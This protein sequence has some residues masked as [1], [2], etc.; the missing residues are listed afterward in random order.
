MLVYFIEQP[1]KYKKQ[2]L[3]QDTAEKKVN[4]LTATNCKPLKH[5]IYNLTMKFNNLKSMI[6]APNS[7]KHNI[8]SA[9]KKTSKIVQ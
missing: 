7:L 8:L 2:N 3:S 5:A 9:E 6:T 4:L 1:S